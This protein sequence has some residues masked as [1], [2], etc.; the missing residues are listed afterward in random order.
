M[1]T[2]E[3]LKCILKVQCMMAKQTLNSGKDRIELERMMECL[4]D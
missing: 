2:N 4:K 3:L 1:T